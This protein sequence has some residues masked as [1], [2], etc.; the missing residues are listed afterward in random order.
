MARLRYTRNEYAPAATDPQGRTF[1]HVGA[2]LSKQTLLRGARRYV[3]RE[4]DTLWTIAWA[5]YRE[6]LDQEQD[7]RP[8]SFFD[9]IATANDIVDPLAPLAEGSIMF[10]P[11]IEILFSEVRVPPVFYRRDVVL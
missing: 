1:L 2:P 11:S 10:I 4:G 7:L 9:V 8:T 5:A 6:V 3:V